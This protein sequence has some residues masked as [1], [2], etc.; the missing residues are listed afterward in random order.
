MNLIQIQDRLKELPSGQQTMQLLM[1]YANGSSPVVPPY[2]ALGELQRRNKIMQEQASA[3]P[4]QGTVKDQ[5]Q[6]QAS[7][8]AS[9]S[10]QG[11]AMAQAQMAPPQQAT[12]QPQQQQQPPVQEAVQ[13]ARGGLLSLLARAAQAKR[14]NSGGIIAFNEA[15]S[16]E[17]RIREMT[18]GDED[19]GGGGEDDYARSLF[20]R[21]QGEAS[22]AREGGESVADIRRRLIAST[23]EYAAL[24][25]EP[26]ADAI[27]RLREYQQAR[28]AEEARRREE[29]AAAKPSIFQ[30][31][32]D[33]ALASRGQFGGAALGAILGRYGQLQRSEDARALEAEQM[34]RMEELK[35]Q[36]LERQAL[37]KQDEIRRAQLEGNVREEIK[38]TGDRDRI[39]KE[40]LRSQL[41]AAGNVLGRTI[42][43]EAKVESAEIAATKAAA[44]GQGGPYVKST[45]S[46]ANGNVIAIMSDGS[47]R[48]LGIQSGEYNQRLANIIR[49]MEKLDAKFAKLPEEE[50]RQR[51]SIRLSGQASAAPAAPAAPAAA[52][53]I[54]KFDS[55]G[56]LIQ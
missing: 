40:I 5:I 48:P 20:R 43:G 30:L 37:D 55:Q 39:N 3:Q 2:L 6:Q 52:P 51:A 27:G 28:L 47:T 44:K 9:L 7:G 54:L 14:M 45:K 34:R 12:P 13:A 4:P 18:S 23:P 15:G 42:S 41:S 19:T 25:N 36:D 33:A 35:V 10:Q 46:D 22:A 38:L 16:V 24:K 53:K 11:Q 29:A 8:I 17:D 1:G 32:G 31:L 26:M 49:D 56:R 50:K 21:L